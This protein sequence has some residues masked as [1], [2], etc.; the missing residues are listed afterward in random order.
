MLLIPGAIT[1]ALYSYARKNFSDLLYYFV[2]DG[3]MA[4]S[5][6]LTL[7]FGQLIF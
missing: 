4:L 7:L 1:A 6:L 5:A 3:L 2:L